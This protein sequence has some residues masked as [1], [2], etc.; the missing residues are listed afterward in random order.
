MLPEQ[1]DFVSG[2]VILIDKPYE[3]TSFGV[4]KKIRNRLKIK[5]IG[6]AGTLDPLATGLLILCTGKKTKEINNFQSLTKEY[7]G[8]LILGKVSPSYDLETEFEEINSTENVKAENIQACGQQFIGEIQQVPPLFSAVKLNGKR[9]YE[10]AR[11]GSKIKLE[12]KTVVI[13]NLSLED[14]NFP[15]IS[16]KVKCSKGTYIRSLVRDIG[17]CL[18]CGATMTSL[19]RTAIGNFKVSEAYQLNE[20]IQKFSV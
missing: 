1:P 2:E 7:E 10:Y 13:E 8:T 4:V 17:E 19:K 15:E 9:A 14:S 3:W 16:F 11:E 5:K 6:H 18:G 12:A 20:L